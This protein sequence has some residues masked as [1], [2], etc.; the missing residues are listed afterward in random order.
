[1]YDNTS[2]SVV[3]PVY[4]SEDCLDELTQRLF[5]VL[6][7]LGKDY[8]IVL[9]NDCSRDNSWVKIAK[10][11]RTNNRIKGISLKKNFGQDNA[12]MA[13]LN[14]STGKSLIIMDDDLQ[15]D[16][17][18]MPSLLSRLEKGYDVCYANF[19]FKKQSWFKNFGSWF[20]D[21]VASIVIKK[22]KRIYLS[23]Y[24]AIKRE[25]V[26][27]MVK[28][29][30]PYPYIDGLIFRTTQNITQ[31]NIKHHNRHAG[32]GNYNLSNSF[33]VWLKLATN[34]SV[35]PLRISTYLGFI[36]SGIGFILS[37]IFIIEKLLSNKSPAGWV[38]LVVIILIMG[39]IQLVA[40][41][42]IGE[43]VGRSFLHINED[44]QFTVD[45]IIGVSDDK[46]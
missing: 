28:Y 45:K 18:D 13:G 26:D 23:P 36:A 20:N 39:G 40:I 22:P 9:V 21:K 35:F 16:P 15:H 44:P 25:V 8:E 12:I 5:N 19:S 46:A 29:N 34:F 30:G 32:K 4:N 3:I 43:Y 7:N 6:D 14:Y 24:K 27:E 10:L 2:I 42:I 41:G 37:F 33:N 17:E 31:V 38:S 1:M 11:C